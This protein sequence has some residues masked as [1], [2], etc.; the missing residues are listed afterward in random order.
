MDRITIQDLEV[1]YC[2]GVPDAERASPQRLHLTV[3]L[4]HD[5]TAAG[6]ADDVTKTIDYELLYRR[7][8]EFGK[9]RQWRLIETLAV[10]VAE[11]LV[12]DF[13]AAQAEVEVKKFVFPQAAWVSA[14]VRRS[15]PS[16]PPTQQ[17]TA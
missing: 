15:R 2:V 10:D 9:G 1:F 12:R 13:G 8:L 3:K 4:E 17:G 6:A 5:F 16:G 11:M 14:C 7:M